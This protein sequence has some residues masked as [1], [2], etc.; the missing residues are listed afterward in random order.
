MQQML[1]ATSRGGH[2]VRQE[3]SWPSVTT[4]LRPGELARRSNYR[5]NGVAQRTELQARAM[6]ADVAADT[7]LHDPEVIDYDVDAI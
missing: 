4:I 6:E 5:S 2:R 3:I 1:R 7:L